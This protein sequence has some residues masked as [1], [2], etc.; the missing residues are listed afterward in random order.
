MSVPSTEADCSGHIIREEVLKDVVLERI[1]AVTEIIRSDVEGFQE[2]WLHCRREDQEKSIREDK[3]RL[4]QAKKRLADLDVLMTRIY[5]DMALGTLSQERYQKMAEGY[6]AE[7]VSLKNEITG[8]EDW[9]EVREDMNDGL[10]RFVALVERDVDIPELTP[11]IVNEFIKRI[12][13][14]APE[15]SGTRR[16]QK[17]KIIFNFMDELDMPE[18][19]EPVITETT[20]GRGK[21]A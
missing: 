15:K 21:T 17:V 2:D 10:D 13:V 1:R 12:I 9:M 8:L 14:Y 3:R 5:E 11:T 7:Q 16:I 6:E 19:G 18:I 20:Y 4:T